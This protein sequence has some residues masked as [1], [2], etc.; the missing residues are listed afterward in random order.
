MTVY[1]NIC[2]AELSLFI[3]RCTLS[4]FY[5]FSYVNSGRDRAQAWEKVVATNVVGNEEE[6]ESRDV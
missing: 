1:R 3:G 4:L 5:R 6:K 2:I